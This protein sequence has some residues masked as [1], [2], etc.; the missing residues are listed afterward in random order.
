MTQS[1]RIPD[2]NSVSSLDS[3]RPP[4]RL[5]TLRGWWVGEAAGR[6]PRELT[7]SGKEVCAACYLSW[8]VPDER[9]G[10]ARISAHL[11]SSPVYRVA[12]ALFL[13]SSP[14]SWSSLWRVW[15]W[16]AQL[17]CRPMLACAADDPLASV[18]LSQADVD[19]VLE[20]AMSPQI[21]SA[22]CNCSRH[23]GWKGEGRG[24]LCA[25]DDGWRAVGGEDVLA[26][27]PARTVISARKTS[28]YILASASSTL[29]PFSLHGLWTM[30]RNVWD[31]SGVLHL[32]ARVRV[33][34][35]L[36]SVS[37]SASA[38]GSSPSSLAPSSALASASF[39]SPAQHRI[40]RYLLNAPALLLRLWRARRIDGQ[41]ERED[42][43]PS[44]QGCEGERGRG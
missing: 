24:S 32:L 15:G 43:P 18:S 17:L 36:A 11:C 40:Q 2:E 7:A 5:C 34:Y 30:A 38:F 44:I 21:T 42:T 16:G 3:R 29:H 19:L 37:A 33:W 41:R 39:S 8:R 1:F 23:R 10:S 14:S 35:P 22:S 20:C 6:A 9:Q 13:D 28:P 12:D 27:S 31:A 26:S 4:L 25:G